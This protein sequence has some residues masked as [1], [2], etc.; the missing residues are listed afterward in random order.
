MI[1]PG[2]RWW[3]ARWWSVLIDC[4]VR[5]RATLL[6]TYLWFILYNCSSTH[7]P[8]SSTL[9]LLSLHFFTTTNNTQ[10]LSDGH[11]NYLWSMSYQNTNCK[12]PFRDKIKAWTFV[13]VEYCCK[14]CW[15]SSGV[16]PLC[17]EDRRIISL[18]KTELQNCSCMVEVIWVKYETFVANNGYCGPVGP[19]GHSTV[20]AI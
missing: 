17:V 15:C 8:S 5:P 2:R 12:L 18:L 13:F 14:V 9:L 1:L 7:N 4:N 20:P 10:Q 16:V 11:P 3:C 6:S 19:A